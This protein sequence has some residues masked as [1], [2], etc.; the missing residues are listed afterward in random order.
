MTVGFAPPIGSVFLENPNIVTMWKGWLILRLKQNLKDF[1]DT[2][3]RSFCSLRRKP[4]N[5]WA[6][7]KRIL[8]PLLHGMKRLWRLFGLRERV[9]YRLTV[10]WKVSTGCPA[11]SR[12]CQRHS[13]LHRTVGARAVRPRLWALTVCL[14]VP[15]DDLALNTGFLDKH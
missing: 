2:V 6:E 1:T 3:E 10:L 14:S 5:I 4:R 15:Y 12:L 13:E 8:F 7:R 9:V 11:G